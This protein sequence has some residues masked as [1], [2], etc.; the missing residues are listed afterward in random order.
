MKSSFKKWVIVFVA[1]F[2]YTAVSAQVVAKADSTKPGPGAKPPATGPKPYA[3]VITAK[4]KTDNGLFKVH[5]IE[6]KYFYEI[7][8]SLLK[9]EI[10]VINRVSKAPSGTRTGALSYAGD[11]VGQ[12]VV[13]FE[14]GPNNKLFLRTIS[15]AEYAKDSTS[16]MFTSLS[17]S[18]IQPIA[19]SFDIKAFS[20]DSAGSVID[21]TDFINGDNDVLYLNSG[22]KSA[23]RVGPV[24]TDKSYI[25]EVKSFPINV[26]VVAVKTYA[27]A[28]TPGAT[29]GM[30]SQGGNI[31]ME[32]NS[33][34]VLLPKSPMQARYFDQRVGYF[35]VGYTDFDLNP[36]GIKNI[37][38]IKRWRLEP[39]EEDMEKYKRG[40]LVEPKKPIIFYI[41]PATPAKW[42]P[43][44]MQ[45]VSDWQTAF[46][47]AGFKNAIFGKRAPTKEENPEWSLEDARYSAIVYKPSTIP[48]ASGPSISDP[49]SGE[50]MESH[51]NWYHNVMLILR[52]W[53]MIQAGPNDARA[54]KMIFDDELMGQLIR[55][56]SS[57]E[58][59]HTLG[60]RHN[61]GSSSTVPVE[62]LR[63][64]AWVEANGHTPSIMDYARF[65]YVAQPED[66]ISDKGIFPKIGDYDDWA[67][68]WGYRRFLQYKSPDEEKAQL[69]KWVI[70][71]LK[72]KRLWFG[73]GETNRDD[74]RN[75]TEQVGD[76]AIKGSFYGIKNLQRIVPNLMEWTKEPN[77]TYDGLSTMYNEVLSQFNRYNNHVVSLV[78]GNMKTPK[79]VEESGPVFELVPEAK[80]R[81]AVE[82][83]N[84]NLFTT[85]TWI[86]SQPILD[87]IGGS[88]LPKIG[89]LQDGILSS[90]LNTQ[91]L[92]ELVD[93]EAA[94][95]NKAY[96]V[97]ELLTDLKKGI[98]TELSARKPIDIYRR[99]LQ[100][101]YVSKIDAI[102][103]PPAVSS[104][105]E[106]AFFFSGGAQTDAD[107]V[108]VKSTLRAHLQT[109]R[110]EVNAT[111]AGTSDQMTK[112]HL[113]DIGRRIE[114][115]LNPKK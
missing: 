12:N 113:Q 11:Q 37:S 68:E 114:N 31:T 7:P 103:N 89:V 71:K 108:D 88:A 57:H 94:V 73:D 52:N 44:L 23:A 53:Y 25:V 111:T 62:N 67:I 39:K 15:F 91:T 84:K 4:A 76:D 1:F 34:M 17:N 78:G 115:A 105:S 99:Q 45:G 55:F 83:L 110:S 2:C 95:G 48:N 10:L 107:K 27:R 86:I 101:S 70:E 6:D 56:V 96:Q 85:P 69:N 36:Q 54:R 20:K 77:E 33:S 28:A 32:L 74:P 3:E 98:W 106:M 19:A 24:Q 87:K 100:K 104:G 102:L 109:L 22:V 112:I 93:A 80:Q 16:P 59:G 81:E 66:N 82:H 58:V 26:E 43:Y 61:F 13:W 9:R 29:V 47:K 40:E 51:I 35:A 50:I 92:S 49:R 64:K 65:N 90:L 97:I 14:K 42:I 72:N 18:N 41:D 46:E 8:D 38:M 79:T 21:M 60:L 5:K 63:N 30:G 75:L